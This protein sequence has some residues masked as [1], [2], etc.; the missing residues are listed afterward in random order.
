MEGKN[1]P[2][3]GDS[4][5]EAPIGGGVEHLFGPKNCSPHEIC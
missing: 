5:E 3:K 4:L 2:L 1:Q